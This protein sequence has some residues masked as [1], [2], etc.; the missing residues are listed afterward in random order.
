MPFAIVVKFRLV[1]T[2]EC[3]GSCMD[4]YLDGAV[5]SKYTYPSKELAV[6]LWN[7]VTDV[8]HVFKKR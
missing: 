2:M 5:K 3:L 6:G 4:D 1:W 7:R 8:V